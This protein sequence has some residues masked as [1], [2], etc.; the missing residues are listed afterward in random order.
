MRLGGWTPAAPSP[1][2][3]RASWQTASQVTLRVE[4]SCYQD[5]LLQWT[6]VRALAG[7]W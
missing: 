3:R 2:C 5:H 1:S 4:E 7:A 6:C